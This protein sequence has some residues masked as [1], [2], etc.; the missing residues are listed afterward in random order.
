MI[1]SSFCL[2][3]AIALTASVVGCGADGPPMYD[4]S[5]SVSLDGQP[6]RD[7]DIVFE[8]LDQQYGADAGK[9]IDGKFA[10][11]AKGGKNRVAIRA[12]KFVPNPRNP[13]GEP[14]SVS[15][16]PTKYNDETVLEAEVAAD[17]ANQYQFDLLSK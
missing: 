2:S 5:G 3:A 12:A 17:G 16:V 11:K 4:V 15:L 6:L 9:V 10:F 14:D 13:D 7:G 8:P 1:R